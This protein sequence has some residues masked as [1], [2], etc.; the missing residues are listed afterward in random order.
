[1]GIGVGVYVKNSREAAELY[2]SAF[3]LILGYHVLNAD[4]SYY[5]SELM[6]GD[7]SILSVVEAEEAPV[8]RGPVQL[9]YEFSEKESLLRA[10]SLL[11]D[12]GEVKL[13]PSELPW[14][15]LAAV[16]TDRFR[17]CWFLSLPQHRPSDDAQLPRSEEFGV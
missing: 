16:V 11:R 10:F 17:V 3:G 9:G 15:P 1:M 6:R 7:E 4:G 8:C 5:H 14:S 12:G 13:P 2:M